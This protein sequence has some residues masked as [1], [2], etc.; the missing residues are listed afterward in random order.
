MTRSPQ[1]IQNVI[2]NYNADKNWTKFVKGKDW[3]R[4]FHCSPEIFKSTEV[5]CTAHNDP[6]I[7]TVGP[8]HQTYI[9]LTSMW[10]KIKCEIYQISK[11]DT[12][13]A[14]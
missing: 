6:L 1:A 12:Y 3:S 14:S 4:I 5:F 7:C 11:S 9:I 10:I 13:Y 2:V 8:Y